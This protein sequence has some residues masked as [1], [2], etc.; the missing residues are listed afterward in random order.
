V[1]RPDYHSVNAHAPLFMLTFSHALSLS[2]RAC[3]DE[4]TL[5]VE[6]SGG[7]APA[8]NQSWMNW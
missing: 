4:T 5:D 7:V 2:R 1:G 8:S 6:Q 3:S